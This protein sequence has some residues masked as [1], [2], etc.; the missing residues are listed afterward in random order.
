MGAVP[1][2]TEDFWAFKYA[3]DTSHWREP[4]IHFLKE[5][6]A[7]CGEKIPRER[8]TKKKSN[9]TCKG[10]QTVMK[11]NFQHCPKCLWSQSCKDCRDKQSVHTGDCRYSE[12]ILSKKEFLLASNRCKE[13]MDKIMPRCTCKSKPY[14]VLRRNRQDQNLFWGCPNFPKCTNTLR[15][16]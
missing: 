8:L 13:C 1:D 7:I 9:V 5:E 16:E 14:M 15:I 3:Q 12:K 2:T 11:V 10:C 4:K 6:T